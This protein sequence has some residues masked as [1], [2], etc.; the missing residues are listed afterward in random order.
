[1]ALSDKVKEATAKTKKG[2]PAEK[3]RLEQAAHKAEAFVDEHAADVRGRI[4]KAPQSPEQAQS[5][6]A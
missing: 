6:R 1:M 5:R 2:T 4:A 3:S